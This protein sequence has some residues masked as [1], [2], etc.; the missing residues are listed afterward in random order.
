MEQY[1]SMVECTEFV[2]SNVLLQG[3]GSSP[4]ASACYE[5]AMNYFQHARGSHY[6]AASHLVEV[7]LWDALR[8]AEGSVLRLA[9]LSEVRQS[10]KAYNTCTTSNS[11]GDLS[12][13]LASLEKSIDKLLSEFPQSVDELVAP[14]HN[15][16][17]CS[18]AARSALAVVPS[19]V[20]LNASLRVIN[21]KFFSL[22][23]FSRDMLP[24][25]R[26]DVDASLQCLL[27]ASRLDTLEQKLS[28][29]EELV[30]AFGRSS[31]ASKATFECISIKHGDTNLA[32]AM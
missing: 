12:S 1:E 30:A 17:L 5:N 25:M 9:Q 20:S 10:M 4:S 28:T 18:A 2:R 15:E 14:T 22:D 16:S 29:I 13:Q 23:S 3:S 27:V 32:T 31:A 26:H 7:G 8:R 24:L 19:F 21:D 11:S 6:V